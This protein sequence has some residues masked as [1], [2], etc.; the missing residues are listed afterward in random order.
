[1]TKFSIIIAIHVRDWLPCIASEE[2]LFLAIKLDTVLVELLK[3][4]GG[5]SH[6]ESKA[7][8]INF[9]IT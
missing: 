4:V 3:H 9:I 6:H 7:C 2:L 8:I 1:M 5:S